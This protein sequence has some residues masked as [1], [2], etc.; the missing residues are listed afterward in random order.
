ME[1]KK[2]TKRK[3]KKIS[4]LMLTRRLIQLAAFVLFPGLFISTFAALKSIYTAIIGGTFSA[5]AMAGQI[6]LAVSMLVITALMGRFFCGFLCAFGSMGDLLWY[7]GGKLKI[8]RPKISPQADRALKSVKYILLAGIV[9]FIWTL[10]A[11]VLGGTANPWTVFGMYAGYKGWAD[12]SALWSLGALLLLLIMAGSMLIER[13]FCRYLCPLGA[14][15]AI[16]SKFRL[17]KIRKPRTACGPCRACTR[18]CSMG[19][20]LYKGDVVT[21]AECIDCMNCVDICP[22]GN[23]S[24]N[25]KPAV[26]AAVAVV[27]M[28]G[29]YFA[30]NLASTAA[31]ET[32]AAAAVTETLDATGE[33]VTSGAFTDGVYTGSASGYHGT[34]SVQ[35][36][37]ENG[38]ITA[39]EVLSTGDDAEFF[40]QAKSLVIPQII[41]AQS[42]DVDTVSGATFSSNAII[43]AVSDAL[44]GALNDTSGVTLI[45]TDDASATATPELTPTPTPEATATP[46]ATDVPETAGPF[47]LTDGVYTG[48]GTGFRGDTE[49]SVTVENGYITEIVIDSYR[50]DEQYFQRA[51]SSVLSAILT[52]QSPDVDAV[53]GAT[54]SSNGIMEAV[55]DALNAEFTATTP[56]SGGNRHGHN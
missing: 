41:S 40:N 26:A 24:A 27:A 28:S 8:K 49:V 7:L 34:T 17:F 43:G 9:L 51:K 29:M 2:I 18:R 20:P 31:A 19:I 46:E 1:E 23:V 48:T 12:L 6:V 22:R 16:V 45:D 21:S 11:S 14:V 56:S 44:S 13:F 42:V 47:D 10:G 54:Y 38:Y 15:F 33:T 3:K 52:A 53:S 55:A 32:L 5:S 25:P 35:V 37:V 36:T 50:D 39:V 30:G 4:P